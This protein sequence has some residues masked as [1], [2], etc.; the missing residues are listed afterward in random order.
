MLLKIKYKI[1][2]VQFEILDLSFSEIFKLQKL[3]WNK[4]KVF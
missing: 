4:Q 2:R 1:S 3:D